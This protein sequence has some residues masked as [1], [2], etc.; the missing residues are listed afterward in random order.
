[1]I[2]HWGY[3]KRQAPKLKWEKKKE[4]TYRLAGDPS[5]QPAIHSAKLLS[6]DVSIYLYIYIYY[7]TR[8]YQ[9][10]YTAD[11]KPPTTWCTAIDASA[12]GGYR[13][14]RYVSP[15]DTFSLQLISV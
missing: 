15:V 12:S 4:S 13:M 11:S 1:M 14:V 5:G 2:Y 8:Q 9:Y 10:H 3:K 7:I 6:T